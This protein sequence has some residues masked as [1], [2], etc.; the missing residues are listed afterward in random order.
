MKGNDCEAAKMK[1]LNSPKSHRL[2]DFV[3]SIRPSFLSVMLVFVCGYLWV[4]NETT[5]E[6]LIAL[7]SRIHC[8]P[9]GKRGSAENLDSLTLS[10]TTDSA[11]G[12]YKK[13]QTH[14]S[15]GIGYNAG[16]VVTVQP[17]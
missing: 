5:N 15:E 10:P 8:F 17:I 7:E 12:L 1:S 14:I 6:R 13:M 3:P 9:C 16:K 4:K 11:N 2:L